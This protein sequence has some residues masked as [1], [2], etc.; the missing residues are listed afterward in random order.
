ME[1]ARLS[2]LNNVWLGT[3]QFQRR[4]F[5]KY[6]NIILDFCKFASA[7]WL[8]TKSIVNFPFKKLSAN[9]N[10]ERLLL[11]IPVARDRQASAPMYED[12]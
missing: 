10:T 4:I 2:D 7:V 12:S 6:T 1:D 5:Q 3:K 8:S 11:D 9:T